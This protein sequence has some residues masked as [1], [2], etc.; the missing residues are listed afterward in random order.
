MTSRAPERPLRSPLERQHRRHQRSLL[1]RHAWRAAALC[2]AAMGVAV[3]VGELVGG[4]PTL[5]WIR[6]VLLAA[7][8]LVGI[9]AAVSRF[10]REGVTLGAFLERVENRF[11][12]LRSWIRNAVDF[13]GSSFEHVS[14]ALAV[15]LQDEAARRLESVR[16]DELRPRIRPARPLLLMGCVLLVLVASGF[17]WPA[18]TQRSWNTLWNPGA[19]APP[20][21]LAV[22]P[23]SIKVSPGASVAVR[24]RVWGTERA[25]RLERR[26]GS[27]LVAVP[28]GRE[29]GGA[30]VWR[31]DL[32]QLTRP[33]DYWVQV[34]AAKSPRYRIDLAGTLA[35]VS[36]D[37]EYVAPRYARLPAQHGT[38][39]RGDL[40]ALR[41]TRAALTVTFDRD[42]ESLSALMGDGQAVAWK[43][44]TPRR[45]QGI[46]PIE[47]DGQYDLMATA[48]SDGAD[49]SGPRSG[50]FRYRV[51]ALADAPPVLV[52]RIPEGDVDLPAGQQIPL[53]VLAQ[54]D[55]GLT[56]LLLQVRKGPDDPW[57]DM[58]LAR[59]HGE[60]REARF[61]SHWDASPIGLL[62]GQVASFRMVLFDDNA[63]SGRGR[64]VS[65][66]FELRFPSLADLYENVD[67]RQEGAQKSL[68]KVTEQARDLQKTL[69][70]LSR[71]Q[72]R[73]ESAP[74]QTF[75]RSE[76][77]R[78]ALQRQQ[79][80]GRQI[81]QAAQ[82][83][84][85]SIEQSAEREAFNKDLMD[86]LRQ[87]NELVQQIQ[88]PE[89]KEALRKMQEALENLDRRALE[90]Q[91]PQWRAENKQMLE[92]LERTLE[93]LKKLR[94]E[95]RLQALA[96]RA[97][98]LKA[99][100]DALNREH[101]QA[102][103]KA[104]ESKPNDLGDR[105]STRL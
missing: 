13:E 92:N 103:S 56:E 22:E 14:P 86:K 66:E 89:F 72:P 26:P 62:P 21:R 54:D 1:W 90:Q 96:Q 95:E 38:S 51:T 52:V 55:L 82:E 41:G 85:K 80:I 16:V 24:A 57:S 87:V 77:L 104:G 44:L 53:D 88:S 15:A 91:M 7:V 5:A 11:P 10:T 75:E 65:P 17:V 30:R 78:S 97:A 35:P 27:D 63:V 33:Q 99:Q 12:H 70:K 49:E 39:A 42:L 19:A 34:L 36:F 23:G 45:W 29:D 37:I 84:Q 81:D 3:L 102:Q 50:R 58:S 68:E 61:E 67:Q 101:E 9:G 20:V 76:E 47:R 64:A 59:F 46:I 32:A 83:L 73:Q 43:Q 69:D 98:E 60:P 71:Q 79:E 31:F 100:Q 18:R 74:S 94:D 48:R 40:S 93:L 4:G 28:E 25:P 105:K 8:S 2:V 6:L